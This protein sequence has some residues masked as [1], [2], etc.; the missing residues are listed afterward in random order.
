MRFPILKF[1]E[2]VVFLALCKMI[3]WCLFLPSK[4][5]ELFECENS[6]ERCLAH[7]AVDQVRMNV[8]TRILSLL[9]YL[10]SIEDCVLV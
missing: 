5:M 1:G 6:K 8:E 2:I 7:V 3:R 4:Q 10:N 9:M